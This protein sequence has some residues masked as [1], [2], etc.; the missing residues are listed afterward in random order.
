[1]IISLVSSNISYT[2]NI[3]HY[4]QDKNKNKNFIVQ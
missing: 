3:Y 1:M 2:I 4:V